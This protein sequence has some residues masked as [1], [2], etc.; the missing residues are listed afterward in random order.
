MARA[1][2]TKT[3]PEDLSVSELPL[4][5]IQISVNSEKAGSEAE[6]F[7]K[8]EVAPFCYLV[9]VVEHDQAEEDPCVWIILSH[10]TNR[11]PL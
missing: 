10:I 7:V 1:N 4:F 9:I 5:P 8:A 6:E 11:C 2:L 3:P